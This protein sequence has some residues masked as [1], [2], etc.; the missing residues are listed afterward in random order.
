[1]EQTVWRKATL[2]KTVA[3]ILG[4]LLILAGAEPVQAFAT[5][6]QKVHKAEKKLEQAIR[7]YGVHSSQAERRRDQLE[8]ARARCRR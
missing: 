2:L 8:T 5:C 4:A 3:A 1:M 7:R 6:Q